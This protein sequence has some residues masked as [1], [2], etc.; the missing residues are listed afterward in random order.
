MRETD[1]K[2]LVKYWFEI[3]ILCLKINY[4]KLVALYLF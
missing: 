1:N 2:W 3:I 4:L